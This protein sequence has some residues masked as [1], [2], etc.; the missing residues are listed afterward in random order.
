MNILTPINTFIRKR[1][2]IGF[3]K[4]YPYRTSTEFAKKHFKD[5]TITCIEIGTFRGGNALNTLQK[6]PTIEKMYLI[7]PWEEYKEY[8]EKNKTTKN[9]LSAYQKT[10]KVLKK[11]KDKTI[12]IKKFSDDALDNIQEKVDFIYID[13]NHSYEFVKKDMINY[14][15]KLKDGGVM[16]GHDIGLKDVSK[17][18]CEFVNEKNIMNPIISIMDWIIVKNETTY[19]N[20]TKKVQNVGE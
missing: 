15:E 6:L 19:I 5:K 4:N 3:I 16:A 10:I 7:D 20:K 9:L 14:W 13:G 12:F 2:N 17:A 11:Y 8:K 1:L 18:F